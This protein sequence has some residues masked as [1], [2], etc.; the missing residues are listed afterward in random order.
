MKN[1]V[2]K[3]VKGYEGIYEISNFGTLKSLA[4]IIYDK[5]GIKLR[6]QKERIIKITK[7][8]GGYSAIMITDIN[9]NTKTVKIHRLVAIAFI[10]NPENKKT[11]NH[12]NGVKHDN[13]IENLEWSTYSENNRHARDNNLVVSKKGVNCYQ[14]KLTNEQVIEIRRI[15]KSI[16]QRKVAKTYNVSQRVIGNVLKRK[17]YTNVV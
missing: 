15:G 8:R 6:V 11:V 17:S 9:K 4:R 5:N 14:S 1:E 13:R 12:I 7:N 10:P 3:S 2:F 16:S